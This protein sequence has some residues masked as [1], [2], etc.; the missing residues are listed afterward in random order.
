[1]LYV[2]MRAWC[3]YVFTLYVKLALPDFLLHF[4]FLFLFSLT[5][6]GLPR[7]EE[8]GKNGDNER[9]RVNK[10]VRG[11]LHGM[12]LICNIVSM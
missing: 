7:T 11:W 2:G 3:P 1:M 5:N 10:E 6:Q 12:S 4:S 9:Q 8:I